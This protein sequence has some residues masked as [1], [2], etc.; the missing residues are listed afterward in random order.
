MERPALRLALLPRPRRPP[1]AAAMFPT[2]RG[3]TR[4]SR[5]GRT[6][7]P[8]SEARS[9]RASTS[10]H[11]LPRRYCRGLTEEENE[12]ADA[13]PAA[14]GVLHEEDL[15][16]AR[17]ALAGSAGARRA[18]AE[19]MQCV[20]RFLAVLNARVGRPMSDDEL[21]DLAQETLVELWRRL[22]TYAGRASLST[23]AFRFCQNVL[24]TRLR[25]TR[26]RPRGV[27]L[28]EVI[29]GTAAPVSSLDFEP[30]HAALDRVGEREAAIVRA[31]HFDE[32]TFE[33]ISARLG[34]PASTAKALYQRG[35]G[36][37]RDLLQPLRREAGL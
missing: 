21:E 34:V 14:G 36:R 37:L 4:R 7:P 5:H 26:R 22:P 10:N 28:E 8:A 12:D 19:E 6:D 35:L 13:A 2:S 32:M 23:W 31:K 17:E 1:G 16:T 27:D 11:D 29:E 18:F 3:P 33:Q 9:R 15:A 25:A 20:P 30:L 24:S